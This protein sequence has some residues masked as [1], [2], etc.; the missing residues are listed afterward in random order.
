MACAVPPY[1]RLTN[2]IDWTFIPDNRCGTVKLDIGV[3]RLVKLVASELA[4]TLV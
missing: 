2:G 1:F 3:E 4:T